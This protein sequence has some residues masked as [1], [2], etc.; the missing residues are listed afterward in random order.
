MARQV[1]YLIAGVRAVV[2]VD[3]RPL[4]SARPQNRRIAVLNGSG[5]KGV[6][7]APF[8]ARQLIGYLERG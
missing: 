6:L 1:D 4:V 2:R 3:N 5:S 8:A 7:Q